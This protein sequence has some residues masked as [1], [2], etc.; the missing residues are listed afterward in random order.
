MNE[1]IQ[2]HYDKSL[3]Q[4]KAEFYGVESPGVT[5]TATKVVTNAEIDVLEEYVD[6]TPLFRGKV[7]F[8]T[9]TPKELE[10]ALSDLYDTN[11]IEMYRGVFYPH[12]NAKKHLQGNSNPPCRVCGED[13]MEYNKCPNIQSECNDCCGCEG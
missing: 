1:Y 10:D 2:F 12:I 9:V 6:F 4:L 11:F 8:V 13:N 3:D 7:A 5:L